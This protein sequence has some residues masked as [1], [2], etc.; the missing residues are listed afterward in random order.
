MGKLTDNLA[1]MLPDKRRCLLT[2]TVNSGIEHSRWEDLYRLLTDFDFVQAKINYYDVAEVIDD[3]T[4]ALNSQLLQIMPQADNLRA[5]QGSLQLAAHILE[6][7][8]TQLVSQL[9]GRLLSSEILV[10]QTFL[11]NAIST[12]NTPWL[13]PQFSSLIQPGGSLFRTLTGHEDTV[14]SVAISADGLVGISGSEDYTVKVWD[15]STGLILA[16]LAGHSSE[17]FAVAI[18][19]A[20]YRGISGDGSGTLQV[21]DL[22]TKTAEF[23]LL[24]HS[25]W[26]A[27]VALTVDGKLAVSAA[28]DGTIR[29][30]DLEVKKAKFTLVGHT[31]SVLSIAVSA[32][33]RW[34]I[35]GSVDRT[36]K[37]WD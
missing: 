35:S 19:A 37:I 15:L 2:K 7:D 5:I 10:V 16:S 22:Q 14:W 6:T 9:L 27:D 12:Q 30:W 34:A 32:D 28:G 21:W 20:G 36:I 3:Y 11:Q 33:G 24:G 1:Q 23:T 13:Q 17:V 26:V 4:K 18:D 8:R 29:C 31:G 25:D